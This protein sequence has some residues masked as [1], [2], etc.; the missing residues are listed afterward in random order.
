MYKEKMYKE[1]IRKLELA[2]LKEKNNEKR[3][4]LY[5]EIIHLNNIM[6]YYNK[7]NRGEIKNEEEGRN[8]V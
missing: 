5:D 3:K 7:K 1:R 4:L 2:L 6:I 8:N